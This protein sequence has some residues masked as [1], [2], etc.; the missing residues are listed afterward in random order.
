M[1][2]PMIAMLF[3]HGQADKTARKHRLSSLS[4]QSFLLIH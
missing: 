1:G 4:F 3:G 2:P